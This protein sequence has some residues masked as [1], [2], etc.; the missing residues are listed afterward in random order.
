MK[1]M[2]ET[3]EPTSME[4]RQIAEVLGDYLDGSLPKRL[5]ELLEWHL[6]GCGPCIAFVNTYRGT[7]NAAAKLRQVEIPPELKQRL[8][9]A[10]R[11][12]R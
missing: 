7:V 10:L 11:S 8:L 9:A 4:C 2:A 12:Y 5:T 6:E 3:P 1:A